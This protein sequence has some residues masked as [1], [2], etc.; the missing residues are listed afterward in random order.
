MNMTDEQKKEWENQYDNLMEKPRRI[1]EIFSDY[2]GE[3]KVDMQGFRTKD[4]FYENKL[5][6][7][8]DTDAILHPDGMFILVWF[9]EVKVTNEYNKSVNIQ[10]LYA[11]VKIDTD[12]QLI[13]KFYLNR[14]TY[15]VSHMRAD[16]MHSHIPGINISDF[17]QFLTPC[18]GSGP[19]NTT[20]GGLNREFDE[21]MWQLFCSELEDFTQVESINGVPYRELEN[22]IDYQVANIA[23]RF[24]Y[25][26]RGFYGKVA[27]PTYESRTVNLGIIPDFIK[28]LLKN[29]SFPMEYSSGTYCLGMSYYD[30]TIL[31]SNKFIEWFNLEDNPYRKL[32]DLPYLRDQSILKEYMVAD[33]KISTLQYASDINNYRGHE[34]K[35]VCK[36][37]GREIKLHINDALP[38]EQHSTILL[39]EHIIKDI[40]SAICKVVNLRYGRKKGK[41]ESEL[42]RQTFYV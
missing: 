7:L 41:E 21:D 14:A 42:D 29:V 10:D 4:E 23:Q 11:K 2:F 28:Y 22:I 15:P 19:I 35:L 17:S 40:V 16:Y 24:S 26:V 18:T 39:K 25:V 3:D 8:N 1:L 9:P 37:K 33:G 38:S 31:I 36:F 30:A 13:G 20:I 32:Y 27:R 12:G 34:G 5:G 6:G